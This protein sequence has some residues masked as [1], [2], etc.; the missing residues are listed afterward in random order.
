MHA[1]TSMNV[2][3]PVDQVLLL[4]NV[5]VKAEKLIAQE[6]V[7][8]LNVQMSVVSVVVMVCLMELVTVTEAQKIVMAFA[9]VPLSMTNVENVTVQVFLSTNVIVNIKSLIAWENVVV[10]LN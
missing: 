4:V 1:T 3:S 5:I 9:E 7:V 2:E 8:V 6:S 10:M